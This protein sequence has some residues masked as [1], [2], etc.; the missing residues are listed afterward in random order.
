M[1]RVQLK[2]QPT[3]RKPNPPPARVQA[4][5]PCSTCG[6]IRAAAGRVVRAVTRRR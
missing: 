3:A 5:A 4:K 2:P 6:K 1:I